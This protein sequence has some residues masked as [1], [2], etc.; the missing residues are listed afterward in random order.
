M[1]VWIQYISCSHRIVCCRDRNHIVDRQSH[2]VR[3]Q[4]QVSARLYQ[5]QAALWSRVH[6]CSKTKQCQTDN[7]DVYQNGVS[8]AFSHRAYLQQHAAL[9]CLPITSS[10][11]TSRQSAGD[12]G[13]LDLDHPLSGSLSGVKR[14]WAIA[15][16]MSAFDPK[17][18]CIRSKLSQQCWPSGIIEH[19]YLT[20]I[21]CVDADVNRYAALS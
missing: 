1:T 13:F 21:L 8:S 11:K 5:G 17:R 9:T 7:N 20:A 15:P 10:L 3:R 18:T 2:S 16:H 12:F 4:Y 19:S 6:W 14:T